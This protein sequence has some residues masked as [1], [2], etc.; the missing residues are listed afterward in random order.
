MLTLRD[1]SNNDLQVLPPAE[2]TLHAANETATVGIYCTVNEDDTDLPLQT[3]SATLDWNDGSQPV[4]YL[5]AASPITINVS[6]LL[7]LGTYA[8]KVTAQNERAPTPDT[9]ATTFVVHVVPFNTA[10]Q[11]PVRFYGPILPRDDGHPNPQ[12]WLFDTGTDNAILASSVKMLLITTKGERVMQPGYGTNLRRILFDLN[13]QAVEAIITQEITQALST[14]EP[15]VRISSL[16]VQRDPNQRN[17][18]VQ[19]M[20]QSRLTQQPF[21]LSLDFAP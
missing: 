21:G 20:F 6:K 15:R 13:I 8:I 1:A 2:I 7:R 14:F 16:Q 12:T 17:V 3:V 10:A 9:A 4:V 18:T 19:A 11:P 5:E